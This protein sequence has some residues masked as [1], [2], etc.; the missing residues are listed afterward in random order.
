MTVMSPS[1]WME[2]RN[3]ELPL[4][5]LHHFKKKYFS[6]IMDNPNGVNGTKNFISRTPSLTSLS[7]TEY[8]ANPSPPRTGEKHGKEKVTDVVPL[9]Y[10]LPS[11]YP[12]VSSVVL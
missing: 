11:G 6:D 5:Q 2:H 8:T 4:L 7:L 9:D 10:L 3:H 1:A 12:D